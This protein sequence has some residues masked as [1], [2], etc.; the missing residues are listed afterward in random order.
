LIYKGQLLIVL[1]L[2]A[3]GVLRA[4]MLYPSLY[5]KRH[6]AAAAERNNSGCRRPARDHRKNSR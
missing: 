4:P 2:V 5:F 1:Q 6:R 3:D